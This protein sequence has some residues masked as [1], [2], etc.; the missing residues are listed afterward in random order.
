MAIPKISS[1]E[2]HA[3]V[4]ELE[5][6][7]YNHERWSETL[8]GTL[9]CRSA[10]DERD[11]NPAAHRLCRFGQWCYSS[12]A[13]VLGEHPA[14]VEIEAERAR[15]HKFAS[16]LLRVTARGETP[17]PEDYERFLSALK[18][19][20]LEIATLRHD[21]EDARNNLDPLT[22]LPNRIAMLTR[23][24]EQHQLVKRGNLSCAVALLDVDD[25]KRINEIQGSLA[26][27][28]VLIAFAQHA[29]A[30]LRS[31]DR[32]FRYGGE[33]FLILLLVADVAKAREIVE[34]LRAALSGIGHRSNVNEAFHVSV[35]LG[36]TL[37]DPE[38]PVEKSIERADKALYAAKA[39][40]RNRTVVW[41]DAEGRIARPSAA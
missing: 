25:F 39:A 10:P 18:L 19:L 20:R 16:Q 5:Q 40:G 11:L 26:G 37:L 7:V 38:V 3:T 8:F 23:L 6:A 35:S 34:R 21:L 36:L 22:G 32:I 24:R 14:F 13:A 2:L 41:E 33:E 29:M 28:K 12:G 31:Y 9:I 17:A 1:E 4:R 27:D 30:H 15:M